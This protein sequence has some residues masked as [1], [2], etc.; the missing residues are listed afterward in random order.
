[1]GLRDELKDLL[2]TRDL[3]SNFDSFA[4]VCIQ[5]DNA[6]HAR[7]QEKRIRPSTY[8]SSRNPSHPD[9]NTPQGKPSLSS[10]AV[11]NSPAL[12]GSTNPEP[13]PTELDAI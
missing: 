4:R 7:Q 6:W 8:Q 2:L 11:P 13:V 12:L 5:L 1:M 10:R 9:T 3:P